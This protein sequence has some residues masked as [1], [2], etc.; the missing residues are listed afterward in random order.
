MRAWTVHLPPDA[1]EP[2]LLREGFSVWA[3]LFGPLWLL[4]HRCWLAALGALVL[5][6]ALAF[7]MPP[8]TLALAVLLGLHGQDLRRWTLARR[9]WRLAHVVMARDEEAALARLLSRAPMLRA[10]WA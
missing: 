7:L 10:R 4:W 8:L 2:V 9:G 3:L 1:A 5:A 6:V